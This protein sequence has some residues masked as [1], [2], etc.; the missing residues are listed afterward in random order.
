MSNKQII[1]KLLEIYQIILE[2]GE[3][4]ADQSDEQIRLKLSGLGV[5]NNNKLIV[6]NPIY[7]LIFNQDWV[8]SILASISPYYEN[9]SG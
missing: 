8:N 5:K 1:G 9:Y 7:K 6:L 2:Q 4:D 3:I